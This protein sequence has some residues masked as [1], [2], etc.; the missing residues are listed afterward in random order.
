MDQS[1]ISLLSVA[2]TVSLG[3]AGYVATYVNTVR[4]EQRKAQLARV[5]RQLRDFYGPLLSLVSASSEAWKGFRSIYRSNT[6][7]FKGSPPPT[8]EDLDA[9]CLW[10]KEVFMPMNE[11]MADLVTKHTDLLEENEIPDCLLKLCAHVSGYRAVIKAW[12]RN[13][14]SRY[15]SV[16]KFPG[17][18]LLFY[19]EE[20]FDRLKLKQAELLG[21]NQRKGKSQRQT[22]QAKPQ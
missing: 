5:E 6:S 8:Q 12:E 11:A 14:Y 21:H 10:M 17:E 16:L 22:R 19:A 4:L 15:N 18:E 7:F 1:T 13:D 9:Y 2:A 3:L 20:R